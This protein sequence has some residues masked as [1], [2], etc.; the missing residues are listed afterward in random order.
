M[1]LLSKEQSI[2]QPISKRIAEQAVAWFVELQADEVSEACRLQWQQWRNAHP[3]HERAWQHL[4]GA[5]SPLQGLDTPVAS[6]VLRAVGERRAGIQRRRTIQALCAVF[7]AGSGAFYVIR[8]GSASK[9]DLRTAKGERTRHL[10]EDGSQLWLGSASAVNVQYSDTERR[11]LL[12]EGEIHI[13]TGEQTQLHRRFIVQTGQ[14]IVQ[15]LGTVFTVRTGHDGWSDIAVFD[16]AVQVWLSGNSAVTRI[17]QAGQQ[18][19]FGRTS[20]GEPEA[21]DINHTAIA[22]GIV[23]ANDMPLGD[24]LA[25]LNR[26]S[27]IALE[28]DAQSSLLHISGS[29]PLADIPAAAKSIARTLELRT[30][31]RK[32]LWGRQT[33]RLLRQEI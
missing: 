10:L 8:Q 13:T 19:R 27:A 4:E 12:L 16:G 5:L 15:A 32:R 6:T 3:E 28:A 26:H 22:D 14:G 33:I 2:E 9:T 31:T 11:L 21:A 25:E 23:R 18:I 24:L 17:V 1:T 29:Y 30:E 7:F 20:I